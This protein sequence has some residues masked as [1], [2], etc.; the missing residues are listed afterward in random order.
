[1]L[2]DK[3]LLYLA[4]GEYRSDY[5][6][7]PY[8]K[9]I[10]VD[11]STAYKKVDLPT[12][13]KVMFLNMEA[14]VA[15]DYLKTNNVKIDCL[16]IIN[17]GLYE[18][19]AIYPF[20]SDFFIGFLHPILSEEFLLVTDIKHYESSGLKTRIG[21]MNWAVEKIKSIKPS[22]RDVLKPGIFS[23]SQ[24]AKNKSNDPNYGNIFHLKLIQV[25]PISRTFGNITLE[26]KHG[27]IW[28]DE[29]QQDA[30][31]CNV[32]NQL[33]NDINFSSLIRKTSRK[34]LL[35]NVSNLTINEILSICKENNIVHIGL[36]PWLNGEYSEFYE[37][38]SKNE[39]KY[40]LK[41]T[42][43]HLHKEDYKSLYTCFGMFFYNK[44]KFLFQKMFDDPIQWKVFENALDM[45]TGYYI[46]K[47]CQEI[48]LYYQNNPGIN[49][50]PF[51]QIK[52]KFDRLRI[53]ASFS[54]DKY[55]NALINLTESL[56][57]SKAY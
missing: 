33:S 49:I 9:V 35:I 26:L 23:D 7:L 31:G 1:M 4:S 10:L 29:D 8:E 2:K 52:L 47:M 18:G 46:D 15:I 50:V 34:I 36:V 28:N 5:E 48:D 42:L 22:E 24:L 44:Y 45:K 16:V 40:P 37:I 55:I 32:N 19:G 25:N 3:T 17:E 30:I 39:F 6:A 21:K 20:Y 38:I 54:R 51:T 27:S 43:Y 14:L 41:I 13:S 12:D 11:K 56:I 57:N 53:Y